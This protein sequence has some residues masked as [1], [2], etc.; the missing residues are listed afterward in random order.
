[1]ECERVVVVAETGEGFVDF[2]PYVPSINDGGTV[3]FQAQVS[4]G[5]QGIFEVEPPF[6]VR[7]LLMTD[8]RLSELIS[9]PDISVSQNCFYA[10]RPSGEGVVLLN[11]Q[12]HVLAVGDIGP[13]G[14]TMNDSGLVAYRAT[15]GGLEGVYLGGDGVQQVA[16]AG[17]EI[18][19]FQGLPVVNEL[20]HVCF[21]ADL[22]DG[23]KGIYVWRQS[24]TET[25]IETDKELGR[26]PHLDDLG[27]VAFVIADEG[28]YV[29]VGESRLMRGMEGFESMR[30]VLLWDEGFIYFGTPTGGELGVYRGE[31]R[32]FGMGDSLFGSTITDLALNPVSI[33]RK[34][35]IAARLALADGR[36]LIVKVPN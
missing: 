24:W 4:D 5:R 7:N 12:H 8:E 14:P 30:G 36:Q 34:C 10:R 23:R 11:G 26:F 2:A 13:L 3:C 9:H 6:A 28:V 1:V 25:V 29:W 33:N 20:G 27:R 19:G 16:I 15:V 18:A 31:E 32:L 22:A 35:D 21:R 17:D